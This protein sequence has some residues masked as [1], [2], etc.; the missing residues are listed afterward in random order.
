MN[1]SQ[2]QSRFATTRWSVVMTCAANESPDAKDAL[3]ELSQRYWYP[4]YAYVRRCGH[5]PAIAQDITGSFLRH[6]LQIVQAEGVRSAHGHFRHY[7]LNE[8]NAFLAGDWRDGIE[9]DRAARLQLPPTELETRYQRD[10]PPCISPETTY[11]RCFALEVLARALKR[12]RSEARKTGHLDMYEALET[13]L[14]A[15][16][17]PGIYEDLARG[18]NSRP[19]ALVVALKRL[20]QRFRELVGEELADT[21]TSA[22]DLLSEQQAL[23][24]VLRRGQV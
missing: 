11:Q 5:G 14:G 24:S 7:L 23:H 2:S 3:T 6:L 16:P 17:G 10:I 12:L 13:F 9:D 15:D 20:R 1:S 18:L 22:E 21:V 8:L 4:V 19:L